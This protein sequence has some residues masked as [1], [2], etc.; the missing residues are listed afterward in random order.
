MGQMRMGSFNETCGYATQNSNWF[1][2]HFG[3]PNSGSFEA[4]GWT[5]DFSDQAWHRGNET[6]RTGDWV[7]AES[8]TPT[9]T[10][11]PSG[12]IDNPGDGATITGS[13]VHLSGQ[14]SD[15]GSG[16][17]RAHFLVTYSG[18]QRQIGPD[19]LTSPFDYYWDM[20]N[21]AVP[22][23]QQISLTIEAWDNAG[24]HTPV[25][26]GTRHFTKNYNCGS[27]TDTVPTST[28]TLTATFTSTPRPTATPTFTL[29]PTLTA[30]FTSTPLPTATPTF[31]LTPT[32]TPIATTT[33]SPVV[34]LF[35]PT[36]PMGLSLDGYLTEWVGR[37]ALYLDRD[38]ANYSLRTPRP[39]LTDLS[40]DIYCAWQ[41][42]DLIFAAR[43]TDDVL[44]RDSTNIWDDDGLEIGI[45]GLGKGLNWGG[46]DDHQF[47]VVTDG[48][49]KDLGANTEAAAIARPVSGGW[50]VELRLP[51]SILQMGAL[52]EGRSI[53]FNV[54][55]N[56]DDDGGS[57]DDWLVWR[58]NSTNSNS[59][60]FG[61]LILTGP[62]IP[63]T[64]TPIPSGISGTYL[65]L[66]LRR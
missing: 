6:R 66:V 52:F 12:T 22:N 43:V 10:T 58:G 32:P 42:N 11:P 18:I 44:N 31:T 14:A 48:T 1:H 35:C 8:G 59:Q 36:A 13:N 41:D 15:G 53:R 4:G 5:L 7:T 26:G 50:A 2:V 21:D 33:P 25:A 40:G 16:L 23:G 45:D 64:P 51:A 27:A 49:V 61:T 28:P 37:P 30:T 34:S 54:G 63:A 62:L 47:T 29:T 39:S 20:C 46:A 17:A 19:F 55:L 56:D 60:N 65:P 38:T 57:R 3:F 9:D 24:N